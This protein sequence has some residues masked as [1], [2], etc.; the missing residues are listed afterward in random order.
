M[1]V[2]GQRIPRRL[3]GLLLGAA[4][5]PGAG[6]AAEWSY[7]PAISVR[8]E[9][10][11][12][13]LLTPQPHDTVWGLTVS[14]SLRLRGRSETVDVSG[15]FQLNFNRYEGMS[16]LDSED[17]ILR[18][19]ATRQGERDR[20]TLAAALVRDSTLASELVDTGLATARRQRRKLTLDPSWQ[21]SLDER[22]SLGL[23][24]SLADV[25]Y[26][27][28]SGTQLV[29]YRNQT[30]SIGVTRQLTERDQGSVTASYTWYES[31]PGGQFESDQ[32]GLRLGYAR[33]FS[34][35]LRGDL[36]LGYRHTDTTLHSQAL[37]CSGP[38]VAGLCIGTLSPVA[39]T[40]K[41]DSN[42]WLLDLGLEQTL[43]T[44]TL[45]V[46]LSR[47]SLPT[48]LGALAER[49]RVLLSYTR[50]LSP[51]LSLGLDAS[52]YQT[53]F[54]EAAYRASDS[55]YYRLEPR[56]IWHLSPEWSLEGRYWHALQQYD[57]GANDARVNG[58][59]LTLSY[60]WPKVA[61]SR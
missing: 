44:G 29:D 49:D 23:G 3:A 22:T 61:K 14:P 46:K 15:E 30:L 32:A 60:Q 17:Q 42:G 24:Y 35:R 28:H 47:E 48:G 10:N 38:I 21:R 19:D 36:G 5:L 34:E 12:N 53:R 33:S 27:D 56:L 2:A 57:V 20:Y 41:S 18:L 55:R 45:A 40:V 25:R 4:L 9:Y 11:D 37:V 31:L 50:R 51:T 59:Y 13:I 26:E 52:A 7:Q 58:V 16:G 6:R 8:G 43:E 39:S 1:S 54:L